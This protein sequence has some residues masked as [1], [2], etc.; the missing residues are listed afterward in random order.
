MRVAPLTLALALSV[1][2][3]LPAQV[4]T[5]SRSVGPADERFVVGIVQDGRTVP[6]VGGR[7]ALRRAPFDVVVRYGARTEVLVNAS[8]SPQL[9]ERAVARE[10][11]DQPFA[12]A[13][14]TLA[15]EEQPRD[16]TLDDE[17]FASWYVKGAE[18]SCTQ[19]IVASQSTTCRRRVVELYDAGADRARPLGERDV[20]LVLASAH[21]ASRTRNVVE[22]VEALRLTFR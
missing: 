1:A 11:L 19:V 17:G 15:E 14:R 5:A 22:H 6:V 8:F 7:V 10:P 4:R 21:P 13:A 18:H 20:Y 3:E 2:A 16:V 12:D 9:Y